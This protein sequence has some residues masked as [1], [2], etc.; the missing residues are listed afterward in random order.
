MPRQSI[1]NPPLRNPFAHNWQAYYWTR[2][3]QRL[4]VT[5]LTLGIGGKARCTIPNPPGIFK[6]FATP[7]G[8]RSFEEDA[9]LKAVRKL[10]R[11]ATTFW[12]VGANGGLFSLFGR[13]ENPGLFIVSIEASTLHYQT[14]SSN[15]ALQPSSR[16]LCLHTAVGDRDGV[17]HLSLRQSGFDHIVEDP[18]S[19]DGV[20]VELRP[21][22]RL[23]TLA[24]MLGTETIDVLKIDVEGY[25]LKVLRGAAALLQQRRIGAIVL[26]SDGHDLRYGSSEAET[27]GFLAALGYGVD[28]SLS[29]V[30][31]ASGNC[32]V[33]QPCMRER[34]EANGS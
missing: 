19:G 33:F 9:S 8:R 11:S 28:A 25:E 21:M 22:A 10:V 24:G 34:R 15:W 1:R 5:G 7:E 4:E 14:L 13:E 17:T 29:R 2:I 23:D 12:D 30:G 16:W 3:L 32:L 31:E 20:E 27:I 18:H 6:T 26:E